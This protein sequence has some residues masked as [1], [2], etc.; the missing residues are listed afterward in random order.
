MSKTNTGLVAYAKAMIGHPYWYGCYGQTSSRAL[1]NAKK[2]QY[3]K[4]Y[5]WTCPASQLG[6]KVF[7]C[8]GLIKGYLWS[9]SIN[10]V[11]KYNASQDVS[12]NGMYDKCK[13]KGT[14]ASMPKIPGVLVFKNGHVGVYIGSGKVIEAKGHAYGV[15]ESRF[16]DGGWL[17][18]GYCPW[19]TYTNASEHTDSKPAAS[20]NKDKKVKYF[21]KYT[22]KS[23][24]IVDALNAI[25]EKSSYAY[26]KTIAKAN[27]IGGYI[28]TPSQN[29]KMLH[30]LKQGKLIKP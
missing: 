21:K 24:S 22:G 25:G 13:K 11:P 5:E 14:I 18:W 9:S 2:K 3:P 15:I 19:I 17:R 10:A 4:Y 8:V 12:A 27:K 23:V 20:D 26:R 30:L 1:Y 28:G 6:K 29:T 16:S 7:D